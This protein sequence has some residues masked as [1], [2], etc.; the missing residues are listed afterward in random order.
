VPCIASKSKHNGKMYLGNRH[1]WGQM[2]EQDWIKDREEIYERRR[3][4]IGGAKGKECRSV[5][6]GQKKEKAKVDRRRE[7]QG[8]I[9]HSQEKGA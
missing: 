5:S 2:P 9:G 8:R 3:S 7:D 1:K 4:R 6:D